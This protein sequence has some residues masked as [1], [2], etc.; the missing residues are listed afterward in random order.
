MKL[1]Y[2]TNGINGSGGLERVL[3]IKASY[4]ADKPDYQVHIL[5]LNK[6]YQNPFYTF[7]SKIFFHSIEVNG[8]PLPY[9]LQYR[10]GIKTICERLK[11]DLISV[12]DDGFK[13]MLF[14]VLFGKRTPI[15]YERHASFDIFKKKEKLSSFQ[16]TKLKL[17]K[18]VLK[19]GAKRFD[20]FVVLTNSNRKEWNLSNMLVIP[21]PL[22]FYTESISSL[23]KKSVIAVGN[24]GYHKAYDRLLPFWKTIAK[25]NPTW[26]LEIYGKKDKSRKL[27]KLVEELN[28]GNSVLLSDPVR[29]IQ[30]KYLNASIFVLPSRSEGFGMVLIE[31]M[32]C[33]VPCIAFDCPN[34][35]RDI[36]THQKDGILVPNGDTETFEKAL[37][38]LIK[39]QRKRVEMGK[40]A[41]ENVKRYLPEN[42]MPQW[43]TL[44]KVLI[45]S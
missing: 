44:F 45:Q 6:A 12:C 36:I 5:V 40:L 10:K 27:E 24:H 38:D 14:P 31:A 7:S 25:E 28:I 16:R 1:L 11:P 35:P 23:T 21:N 33:G 41:R 32:S 39:N 22:S 19:W 9:F 18:L 42:I 8:N 37:N 2:I 15:I 20:K 17:G 4:F 34:G 3:S 30:D 43:D 13:G 26:Q 29:D